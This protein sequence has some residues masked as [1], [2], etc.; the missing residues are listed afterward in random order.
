MC[1]RDYSVSYIMIGQLFSRVLLGSRK[2][3]IAI[4]HCFNLP[5]SRNCNSIVLILFRIFS[6]VARKLGMTCAIRISENFHL[7]SKSC[8][9][10]TLLKDKLPNMT[11]WHIFP[12]LKIDVLIACCRLSLNPHNSECCSRYS[13]SGHLQKFAADLSLFTPQNSRP[14]NIFT[15]SLNSNHN[16]HSP[17]P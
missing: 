1:F 9:F 6:V 11:D 16:L 13:A 8:F 14:Y 2:L 3:R 17:A 10:S 7:T 12:G 15:L 5:L 4:S